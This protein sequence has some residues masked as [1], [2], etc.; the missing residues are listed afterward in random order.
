MRALRASVAQSRTGRIRAAGESLVAG[1]VL[2]LIVG[3]SGIVAARLLGVTDRGR[4]AL[5]WAITVAIGQLA[6][7]GLHTSMAYAVA[8]G[9]TPIAVCGRLRRIV[10]TQIAVAPLI[11]API[12]FLT[13]SHPDT[14]SVVAAA[15]TLVVPPMFVLLLHGL[16]LAQGARRYRVVQV[17]RLVQ[18]SL[19]VVV[20]L[21]LAI[22]G[23]GRFLTV[24]MAYGAT[25][26]VAGSFAWRQGLGCWWPPRSAGGGLEAAR[27]PDPPGLATIA[28]DGKRA[29]GVDLHSTA[30]LVRFGRRSLLSAFGVSEHLAIDQLVVGILLAPA[31]FGLY[32]A[33]L[34]F[35]NLPRYLG[36]SVGYVA[37]PEVAAAATRERRRSIIRR[38]VI[39]GIVVVTPIVA[40]LI[41]LVPWLVPLLFGRSFD[42]A[43]PVAQILLAAALFQGLRRVAAEGLRGM[44]GE[45][46]GTGAELVFAVV[47]FGSLVPLVD[48]Y[49]ASGAGAATLVG[50]I[51]AVIALP[52]LAVRRPDRPERPSLTPDDESQLLDVF[53]PDPSGAIGIAAVDA[54]A[55]EIHDT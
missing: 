20:L 39:L 44:G 14:T 12:V 37:Y 2:Q 46:A 53:D 4:L 30:S 48:R 26:L 41:A 49:G 42:R 51:A 8:A 24:T 28:T 1:G 54:V 21:T 5:L 50:A 11:A 10:A 36:Q 15:S 9:E 31:Q 40:T 18:P 6:T 17:L 43:V 55:R 45:W 16:S 27:A 3:V 19:Y 23:E 35:A 52:I 29:A 33:G 13:L 38:F 47:L 7:M 25:M 32:T 22:T 34:A